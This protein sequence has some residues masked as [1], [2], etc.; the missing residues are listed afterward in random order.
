VGPNGYNGN[1]AVFPDSMFTRQDTGNF[2]DALDGGGD[3]LT[4]NYYYTFDFAET[5]AR[6]ANYFDSFPLDPFDTELSNTGSGGVVE[7]TSSV[8]LQTALYFDIAD[9]PVDINLG[10]R[11][12][13]TD[14]TSAVVRQVEDKIVWSNPTEWQLR[15]EPG[16]KQDVDFLGEHDVLLPSID[17]KVE[18]TDD[19]VARMSM[20]K[21]I[22]RAP[23]GNLIGVRSLSSS[24]KPG[25]RNGSQGNTNLLPYEST[26]FDLS[27]EYYYD[28]A[29][30]ISLGYFQKDVKNFVTTT[31]EGITVDG[32]RD[33]LLGPRAIQAIGDL[34]AGS[35][36]PSFVPADGDVWT[37]IIAN[38]GGE[39][40]PITGNT[41]VFQNSDDPLIEWDVSQPT[42]GVTRNVDGVE[43]AVQHMFGESGFGSG[44]NF[45]LVNGDVEFDVDSFTSQS[46]LVGLSDSANF[47]MFYEKDGLSVKVTYAWRDDF[48][49]GVG[50]AQGSSEAPPQFGKEYAQTDLSVNYDVTDELTV[51]FEGMNITN[52]TEQGYGRYAEQFLYAR[53]YGP[54]YTLGARYTF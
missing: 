10:I 13:Q 39:F 30:Y 15:Y 20:G 51:F 45:T 34:V 29:S 24:P 28:D 32:L 46:P 43:F 47:N 6:L 41:I 16:G 35:G 25:S 12:E 49:I 14:V 37:Q 19:I 1:Q 31:I 23:L 48:L 38:G 40:D 26:N 2:L 9:M 50:Q 8:Y 11:Y 36:D 5:L 52:E 22:T 18:V 54:R 21:T 27:V 7:E 33:P 42:N 4:T 3:A 53:Q 17:I 44:F